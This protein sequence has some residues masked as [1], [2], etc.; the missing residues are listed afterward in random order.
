VSPARPVRYW[1]RNPSGATI[2]AAVSERRCA[3]LLLI[4][5]IIVILALLGGWGYR[6]WY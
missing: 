6:R 3:M 5:A 1:R 2:G 4:I